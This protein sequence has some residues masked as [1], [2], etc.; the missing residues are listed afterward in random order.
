MERGIAK[1]IF[2]IIPN[3]LT[4]TY[5]VFSTLRLPDRDHRVSIDPNQIKEI[6]E[7]V[8]EYEEK[9]FVLD[10]IGFDDV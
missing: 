8:G 1:V 3:P 2:D 7:K 6:V 9:G 5:R 10:P 4:K